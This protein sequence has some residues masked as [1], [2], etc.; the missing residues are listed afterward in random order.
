VLK[1]R[2]KVNRTFH[3]KTERERERFYLLP[4]MGGEASRRKHNSHLKWAV[5]TALAGS[6]ILAALMYWLNH[7]NLF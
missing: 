6:A 7:L 1:N 3:S 5:L 2:R 4:G